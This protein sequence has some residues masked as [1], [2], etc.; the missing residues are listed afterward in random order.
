LN[1]WEI[2]TVEEELKRDDVLGWL[3]NPSRKSSSFLVPYEWEGND[4]A[5]YPDFLFF[6]QDG[7]HIIV[8]ILDPHWGT[9]EDSAAKARGPGSSPRNTATSSAASRSS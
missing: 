7:E 8:D 1:D 6:R 9:H 5:M 2:T 4:V 3:R